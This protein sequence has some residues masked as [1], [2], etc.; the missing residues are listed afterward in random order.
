MP[1]VKIVPERYAKSYLDWLSEKRDWPVSRQLWWGHR[2]P[3]WVGDISWNL[4][5]VISPESPGER[6]DGASR[7]LREYFDKY[8]V[9]GTEYCI[10]FPDDKTLHCCPGSD[11]A[12]K[13]LRELTQY[14][15]GESETPVRLADVVM[16]TQFWIRSLTEDLDVLD[17]WFSS[18]LWPHSTMGWPEKTPELTYWYPTSTLIT[19]RDIITLWVARMVLTG[20]NNVGEVPFREVFI[21]PKILDG[22]GET[23]SK[24]KGNG[25]DPLDIVDK[26]GADAL[27]F[28]L[29]AL[30]TE[31]QDV[32]MAV[33]FE[34]PHCQALIDQT[35]KNRELPRIPCT[36]CGKEFSTQ[37]AKT[38]ADKA[39]PRAAV[40]SERFE[41]ARNFTNK[42]WNAARFALINLQDDASEGSGFR[43]QGSGEGGQKSVLGTQ[44]S[45]LSTESQISTHHSPLTTHL[46]LEDRWLLSRLATVTAGVTE[47]F[48]AYKYAE[49]AKLLYDFAWDEFCSFYVEIAKARLAGESRSRPPG[50]TSDGDEAAGEVPPSRRDLQSKATAQRVLAHALDVLL[51]L[52]HPIMPF[53]TEEIWQNLN[54]VAPH[55]GL[56]QVADAPRSPEW[57]INAPWPVADMS[58]HN[59]ETE[60]RFAVF[61]QALAAIRE[62]R[63]R[64]N[65][66]TKNPLSFAIK[67]DA[68]TAG[69][70]APMAT[71]FQSMANATATG[72]GS[73]VVIPATNAKT[74]LK[75]MEIYVDLA[76]LIDV[77]AEITKNEQLVTKLTGLIKAKEAKLSN[78]SFVARAPAN[79]VQ[80][81]RDSL[82]QMQEQLASAQAALAALEK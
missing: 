11:L 13:A 7:A 36:K 42:L 9:L 12:A 17:T 24:S 49:G 50:G 78:E 44:Y 53:I 57:L 32:R 1:R 41:V 76:G 80:A 22:Y 81:E 66:A 45:V 77:S 28:G 38:D 3:V 16:G 68:A 10:R 20:L 74:T 40:V 4:S 56:S 2:I 18:A 61:Q 5:E 8:G 21:H 43:V 47:A 33:Q 55:R 79:V 69:L 30:T 25:V 60:A 46:T 73:D 52:L 14:R 70:L 51:R 65:I 67:C 82:A 37:W 48:K 6:R 72:F 34:C 23:M 19:S 63:S 62:I 39:L 54:K 26:F 71:Y 59:A 29:A 31:T 15:C 64:Q 35:K 75:S 27:R 58:W